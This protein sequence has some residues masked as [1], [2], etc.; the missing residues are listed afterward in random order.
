VVMV[1]DK[2]VI[3]LGVADGKKRVASPLRTAGDRATTRPHP[4]VDGP[5]FVLFRPG[6]VE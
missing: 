3:A 1:T 6:P 4:V 2:S 5:N